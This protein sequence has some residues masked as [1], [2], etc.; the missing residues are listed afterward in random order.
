MPA[1][2]L[3][4]GLGQRGLAHRQCI[5]EFGQAGQRG[6]QAGQ[7]SWAGGAKR[8]PAEDP[9]HVGHLTQEMPRGVGGHPGGIC[10]H[11]VADGG[12]AV[13]QHGTVTQWPTQPAPELAA[14]HCGLALIQQAHQAELG[15]TGQR[16]L[17]LQIASRHAIQEQR[18]GGLFQA[19]AR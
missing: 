5:D 15:V 13:T 7:V 18:I 6:R 17:D 3:D 19:Q 16:L 1:Q 4:T 9:F 10:P 14:A 11:E 12:M 8:H 2:C